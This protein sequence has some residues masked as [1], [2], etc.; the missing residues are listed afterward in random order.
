MPYTAT[1]RLT[2]KRNPF[3]TRLLAS[4]PFSNSISLSLSHTISVA[5]SFA[6]FSRKD[7]WKFRGIRGRF[8][9]WLPLL[10]FEKPTFILEMGGGGGVES[11]RNGLNCKNGG[12]RGGCVVKLAFV[13]LEDLFFLDGR[14]SLTVYLI[15]GFGKKVEVVNQIWLSGIRFRSIFFFFFLFVTLKF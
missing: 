2:V 6:P 13:F 1:I 15:S 10:I 11:E 7:I 14:L 4:R 9:L 5:L 12:K 8:P 3:F